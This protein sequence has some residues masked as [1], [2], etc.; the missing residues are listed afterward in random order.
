M[1]SAC[2]WCRRG[3][4]L[5]EAPRGFDCGQESRRFWKASLFH[6]ID[7]P[8]TLEGEPPGGDLL[9]GDSDPM[10]VDQSTGIEMRVLC[11]AACRF[12]RRPVG[13]ACR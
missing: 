13:Q 5:P 8:R 9:D 6:F 4:S 12:P 7:E 10:V 1:V 3:H 11:H 2:T